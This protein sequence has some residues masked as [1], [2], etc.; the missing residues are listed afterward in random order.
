MEKYI[1]FDF[2]FY[3]KNNYFFFLIYIFLFYSFYIYFFNYIIYILLIGFNYD[4]I[5]CILNKYLIEKK[6]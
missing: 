4:K 6:N 5:L 1:Y 2:I 3:I